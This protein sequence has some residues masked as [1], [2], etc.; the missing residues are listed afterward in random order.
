[1]LISY[2]L[3]TARLDR[4]HSQKCADIAPPDLYPSLMCTQCIAQK[5]PGQ[6][7]R[8][9]MRPILGVEAKRRV[10]G[11]KGSEGREREG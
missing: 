7:L 5:A 4:P 6:M 10:D 1:M 9:L 3:K 2:H 8:V 11:D